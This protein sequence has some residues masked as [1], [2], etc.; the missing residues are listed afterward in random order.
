MAFFLCVC[1]VKPS[2]KVDPSGTKLLIVE[3][4]RFRILEVDLKAVSSDIEKHPSFEKALGFCGENEAL[5]EGVRV[6][7]A[8]LPG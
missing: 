4:L 6:F 3:S 7:S 2:L 5:P 1:P 8:A